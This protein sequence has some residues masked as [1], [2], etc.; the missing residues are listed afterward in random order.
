MAIIII[1]LKSLREKFPS[2]P[3]KVAVRQEED[4]ETGTKS[5][6]LHKK[7]FFIVLNFIK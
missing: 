1:T 2:N 7:N 4:E 3:I 6:S 5:H